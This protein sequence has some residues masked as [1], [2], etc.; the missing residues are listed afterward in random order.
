MQQSPKPITTEPISREVLAERLIALA[1]GLKSNSEQATDRQVTDRQVTDRQVTGELLYQLSE[2][3]RQQGWVVDQLIRE[4]RDRLSPPVKSLPAARSPRTPDPEWEDQCEVMPPS[5]SMDFVQCSVAPGARVAVMIGSFDPP[6]LAQVDLVKK[7]T[8]AGYGRV[9]IY[10]AAHVRSGMVIEH[11]DPVHRA[12]LIDLTFGRQA[13]AEI[14]FRGLEDERAVAPSRLFDDQQSRDDLWFVV[15]AESVVGKNHPSDLRN[16]WDDGE[17]LW[18][19]AGFVI[20]VEAGETIPTDDLPP[21]HELVS[22]DGI[23]QPAELRQRLADGKDVSTFLPDVAARYI[24]RHRLFQSVRLQANWPL[25]WDHPGVKI[26]YDP[27]NENAA[28]IAERYRKWESDDAN[29]I[30]VVGGDG[31]MLH[32]IRQHWRLRLP[33]VGVNAGH[34]GFLMNREPFESLDSLPLISYRMP[35]LRTLVQSIDET[36]TQHL[37]FSD[38][39]IERQTGQAAWFRLDIDGQ[40]R[41]PKVV[42]D[43]LLVAT[44][45]GSSSYARAMG[46]TPMPLDTQSL[47]IAGS[48]IFRP[49][50]WQPLMMPANATIRITTLDHTGKRPVEAFVDGNPAGPAHWM[51][52]SRSNVASVELAFGQ[53]SD[54]ASKL[55]ASLLPNES[56]I[57]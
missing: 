42:G 29:F 13:C 52:V 46:A 25:C 54:L 3:A 14:H 40:T 34:L 5:E 55:L 11:A 10:P 12:A 32:A 39:W 16:A 50:F 15:A 51:Q 41:V 23:R 33:F 22:V 30:L 2:I 4:T 44:P 35:M 26:V 28:R 24:A 19:K 47:T 37:A 31:T 21:R 6:T 7:L 36:L 8:Q 27:R 56:D 57:F 53:D 43:G 20:V 17:R 9:R 48:N 18:H 38:A 45:S 49:R 1:Q